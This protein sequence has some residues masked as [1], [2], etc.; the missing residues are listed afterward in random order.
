MI[1]DAERHPLME[2]VRKV[3]PVRDFVSLAIVPILHDQGAMGAL[4]LRARTRNDFFD[5]D[6]SL[7]STV[8]NATAIA[9]RN[10]RILKTLRDQSEEST[11]AR[12]EAER[13][14]ELFRRYAADFFES[15]TPRHA[16]DGSG[17]HR[18]LFSNPRARR[19]T[20]FQW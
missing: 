15:A 6:L 19:I 5:H 12:V 9:L 11:F 18:C 14:L 16:G 17:R 7:V 3:E 8:A 20:G 1:R 4:F 13:R 10:A 2:V